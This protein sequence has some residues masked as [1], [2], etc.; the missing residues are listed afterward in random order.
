[1]PSPPLAA[2]HHPRRDPEAGFGVIGHWGWEAAF[3]SDLLGAPSSSLT[4]PIAALAGRSL[5]GSNHLQI[6]Q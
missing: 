6:F 3:R 4:P 2:L 1:M 5:A